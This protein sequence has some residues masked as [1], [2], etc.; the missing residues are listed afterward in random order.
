MTDV[1]KLRD[2]RTHLVRD[3]VR[4]GHL[5]RTENGAIYLRGSSPVARSVMSL[6]EEITEMINGSS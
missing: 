6:I 4:R 3:L 1:K 5:V 2:L